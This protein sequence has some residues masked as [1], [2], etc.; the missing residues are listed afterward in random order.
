MELQPLGPMD[1][2]L[3]CC[4]A[5]CLISFPI[6]LRKAWKHVDEAFNCWGGLADLVIGVLVVII[7][8]F[9]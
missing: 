5:A 7:A 2:L 4:G 3:I 9:W 8:L 1:P 6:R